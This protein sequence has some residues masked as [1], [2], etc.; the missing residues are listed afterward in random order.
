MAVARFFSSAAS[1][2]ERQQLIADEGIGYVVVDDRSLK[3]A[4]IRR[5]TNLGKV[6][7]SKD[8]LLIIETGTAP[9]S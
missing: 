6:V 8:H 5:I 2:E 4:E 1:D 7:Q 9:A 3:A